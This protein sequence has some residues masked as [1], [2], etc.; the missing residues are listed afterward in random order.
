MN[1]KLASALLKKDA[2]QWRIDRWTNERKILE[3]LTE[4]K[5]DEYQQYSPG[6][7]F[8]ESLYLWLKQFSLIS[9]REEAYKFIKK[10]LIFI[11]FAELDHIIK[12]TYPDVVEKFLI[13]KIVE[14]NSS[15]NPYF[16]NQLH[17][18]KQIENLCDRCL[19]LGLSDGARIDIFRR[20]SK[21]NHEQVYPIYQISNEK[22]DELL[23][24]LHENLKS[25]KI[26]DYNN[27]RF[28]IVFLI[29]DFS[30]S[31]LS[32][33][34][35]KD[36]KFKGKIKKFFEPIEKSKHICKLFDKPL[37]ICVLL[38]IAT[39]TAR[40]HIEEE[41]KKYFEPHA[42]I[43]FSVLVAYEIDDGEIAITK[44]K[45]SALFNIAKKY[46]D[47]KIEEKD[48]YQ[49]GD[50]SYP[51]LGYHGCA[52]PLAL[53]HNCPN[54]SLNILWYDPQEYD[55]RGLFPRVERFPKRE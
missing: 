32:F 43:T 48:S 51:F 23:E 9:E 29:D 52:L 50:T 35:C 18:N 45:N 34:R 13:K 3:K 5:Y 12:M 31:G 8:V 2:M 49:T 19:F 46:Y 11:S 47:P 20:H 10:K 26:I 28:K 37:I 55:V 22:T 25:K 38:Y 24:K 21:L 27:Q 6:H 41:A 4:Y 40:Q 17:K 53:Y 54:N 15:L 36:G 33:I 16:I 1:E 14:M 42:Q 39:K 7:R 44:E 30:A